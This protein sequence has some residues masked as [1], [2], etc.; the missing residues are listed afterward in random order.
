M[1]L[2]QVEQMAKRVAGECEKHENAKASK[3]AAEDELLTRVVEMIKPA[4]P[5]MASKVEAEGFADMRGVCIDRVRRFYLTEDG[6]WFRL[7]ARA[8]NQP[9]VAVAIVPS[10]V[11]DVHALGF[12]VAVLVNTLAAQDGKRIESTARI[13][14][15][16]AKLR[17]LATLLEPTRKR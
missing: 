17:A 11:L 4:L 12:V 3:D 15:E 1:D 7:D 9:L 5:A 14:A 6:R 10:E 16:A 2:E 8:Y 13:E